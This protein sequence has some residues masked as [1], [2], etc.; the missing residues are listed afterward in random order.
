M[1]HIQAMTTA[2]LPLGLRLSREASWNQTEAD[3]RR[4]LDLQPDGCFVAEWDGTPV[5]TTTTSIFGPVAWVAM[6]LVDEAFRGRGIGTALMH[7]VLEFL[8]RRRIPTVRLDA[9]PLGQ[10]LYE[11]LGFVEQF[12]LARYEGTLPPNSPVSGVEKV[13]VQRWETLAALDAAVTGTD[14]RSLLLRLFSEEPDR[15]RFWNGDSA[16]GFMFARSG[17]RAVQLGPCIVSPEA[18]PL[19]FADVF[20]RYAGQCVFLDIPVSNEVATRLAEAQ[21]LTVQRYLTRMCRG[22]P[23]GERIEWLWASSGPEK[24]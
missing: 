7:H 3:W 19:L 14:R 4:F 9:T 5:G 8:D 16:T 15:V 20:H 17:R 24:G 1:T 13:P 22:I 10:P 2:D 18:G 12:R 6:V 23:V 11:R 21:G